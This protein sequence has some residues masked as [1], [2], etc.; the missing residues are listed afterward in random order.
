MR[1]E[2][3]TLRWRRLDSGRQR[4]WRQWRRERSRGL[5]RAL[6][7]VDALLEPV[8][9]ILVAGEQAQPDER[10]AGFG[11]VGGESGEIVAFERALEP[12][13]KRVPLLF[14]GKLILGFDLGWRELVEERF[15]V[16]QAG[17]ARRVVEDDDERESLFAEG[18]FPKRTRKAERERDEGEHTQREEDAIDEAVLED[19]VFDR[20]VEEP[21]RREA[22]LGVALAVDEM[23]HHR[24]GDGHQAQQKCA[25]EEIHRALLMRNL[26]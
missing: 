20:A 1:K 18:G 23:D 26:R 9:I 6:D 13:G 10:G 3:R 19:V 11:F 14:R 25:A 8:G 7:F 2:G 17:H 22:A 12:H 16:A 4:F 15:A 21:Q 5:F 24:R